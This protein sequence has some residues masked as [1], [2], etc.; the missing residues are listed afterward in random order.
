MKIVV[1]IGDGK[2]GSSS[3]QEYLEKSS[4]SLSADNI[5]YL[6][7]MLEHCDK[8]LHPDW[9]FRGGSDRF[10]A[11]EPSQA[12]DQFLKSLQQE[13]CNADAAYDK[14]VISNEWIFSRPHH[15][16]PALRHIQNMGHEVEV[17]LYVRQPVKWLIS[18]YTQ[19]GIKHKT[20][21]GR[22]RPFKEWVKGRIPNYAEDIGIWKN[23]V[24]DRLRV[25]NYDELEDV[26]EHFC[27][28]IGTGFI[29]TMNK[30][31]NVV[32]GQDYLDIWAFFNNQFEG[33]VV[34][35]HFEMVAK[36]IGIDKGLKKI[37]SHGDLMPTVSDVNDLQ[38][39]LRSEISHLNTA[40]HEQGQPTLAVEIP[41]TPSKGPSSWDI[42]QWLLMM[43]FNLSD[44][45]KQLQ[46]Q[47][48]KMQKI[49]E[50][51]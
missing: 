14:A 7:I 41:F 39:K 5:K 21:P 2:T 44:R 25:F 37:G 24:Q 11:D 19:W 35:N 15:I 9:Q 10:F 3:I 34:A 48:N 6:G 43:V 40:L 36:Y 30:R 8:I 4:E 45:V 46:D 18:A 33:E 47:I 29:P 38:D 22:V 42:D 17:I 12:S 16:V 28:T 1:H 27:E 51:Q 20:Y 32:P 31:V 26:V 49:E 23:E 13:L 50:K